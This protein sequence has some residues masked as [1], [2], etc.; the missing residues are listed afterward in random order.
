MPTIESLNPDVPLFARTG[1]NLASAGLG[2]LPVSATDEFFAPLSRMLS[3]APPI[4][5]PDK[6]DE[7]GKWMDGW[8]TRRRRDGGHDEAV[9]RLAAPGRILG[10]NVD[11]S[12]FTGNFAPAVS[13]EACGPLDGDPG[14]DA[15]WVT[16]LPY[17]PLGASAHHY[18]KCQNFDLYS[19]LRI[20]IYPDG[21]VARLRVFGVPELDQENAKGE[22]DL[23]SA[24][25]GGRVLA[26]SD[27]HYGDYQRLLAPG[28][29]LNMGDG[30]ETRRR[31]EPGYDWIVI[32]LGARGR[33]VKSVIDTCFF[34]GN[35]P[36]IAWIQ[37]ADMGHFGDG[38]ADA[39]V[40]DSMF[41]KE[42]LP[43]QKLSPDA[44]H[45]YRDEINDIGPVTHVRFNIQPDGGV[46]RLRLFG[47][48]SR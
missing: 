20:S 15:K 23:A 38:L 1:I 17:K 3:D 24:L 13:I 12:H 33:I 28:R 10:F 9:I 37:A 6:F 47:T 32:A 22:I 30:W 7:N 29:G 46:S 40:T 21:G 42:L 5:I 45:S 27:A 36:D 18:F 35:Y 4:F 2:A 16:I 44:E 39:L 31:R 41:W 48:L 25:N 34:K 43:R 14:P 11:T 26:F 8:E 19:H